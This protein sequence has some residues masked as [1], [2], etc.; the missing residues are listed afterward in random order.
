MAQSLVK[1]RRTWPSKPRSSHRLIDAF[2]AFVGAHK[3][4]PQHGSG[5][6]EIPDH[7]YCLGDLRSGILKGNASQGAGA[8]MLFASSVNKAKVTPHKKNGCSLKLLE[9]CIGDREV[10]SHPAGVI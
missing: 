10:T 9:Q 6:P 8:D 7:I 5:V 1:S 3:Q 2:A 4:A